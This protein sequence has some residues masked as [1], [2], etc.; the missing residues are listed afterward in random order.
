MRTAADFR[1]GLDD[2]DA[3][4]MASDTP[5]AHPHCVTPIAR[6]PQHFRL[7]VHA[8]THARMHRKSARQ[9]IARTQGAHRCSSQCSTWHRSL[10]RRHLL[11]VRSHTHMPVPHVSDEN[12]DENSD[13]FVLNENFLEQLVDVTSIRANAMLQLRVPLSTGRCQTTSNVRAPSLLGL[14]RQGFVVDCKVLA[15]AAMSCA[16]SVLSTPISRP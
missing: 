14:L 8:R 11:N 15:V 9:I 13:D 6:S 1:T 12:S 2:L 7:A 4:I 5:S 16:T 3:P 10:K